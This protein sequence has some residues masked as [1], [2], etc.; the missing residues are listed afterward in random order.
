MKNSNR[1]RKVFIGLLAATALSG[2][3]ETVPTDKAS[4]AGHY[5]YQS[6]SSSGHSWEELVLNAD[7]TYAFN[8]TKSGSGFVPGSGKW[9]L[10]Q[11]PHPNVV[12]DHA[13][14]PVHFDNGKIRLLINSDLDE[15]Y[16]KAN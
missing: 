16:V 5:I 10:E 9:Y 1:L 13:G 2:C 6:S 3:R 15:W 7:G 4:F 8:P 12:I 11:G 14:Y